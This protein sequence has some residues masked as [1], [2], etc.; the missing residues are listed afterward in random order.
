MSGQRLSLGDIEVNYRSAGDGPPVVLVHG[1][2]QD[3][4]IWRSQQ[5]SLERYRTIAYDVRGHGGTTI[6]TGRASLDQ[7]AGDLIAMLEE[8]G[9]AMVVG[10][11]LGGTVA[12]S[13]AAARPDLVKGVIALATSS[14]VGRAA[15]GLY[16][17]RASTMLTG[18]RDPIE[19]AVAEDIMAML[20]G[21]SVD[22]SPVIAA[23]IEAVGDGA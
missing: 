2:G 22:P 8:F 17:D 11:S 23:G 15:A 9:P 21:S 6:G 5:D 10:F 16:E 3:H 18:D 13:A 12:L 14:A 4:R 20:K 19:A 1:L 7:L